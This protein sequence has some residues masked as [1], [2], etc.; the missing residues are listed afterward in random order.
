M[1]L[2]DLREQQPQIFA[3]MKTEFQTAIV[4]FAEVESI[5][6]KR[7]PRTGQLEQIFKIL[8]TPSAPNSP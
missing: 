3:M 7:S 4:G 1:S 6:K 5:E 2:R 8:A